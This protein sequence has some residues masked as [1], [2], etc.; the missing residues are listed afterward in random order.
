[1]NIE[2]MLYL[3]MEGEVISRLMAGNDACCFS[4]DQYVEARDKWIEDKCGCNRASLGIDPPPPEHW[5]YA[6]NQLVASRLVREVKPNVW[7]MTDPTPPH[8]RTSDGTD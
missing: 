3:T 1:M 2:Q 5:D 7:T 6:R 4:T 8:E